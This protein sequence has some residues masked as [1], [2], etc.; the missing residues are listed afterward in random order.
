[1]HFSGI[2]RFLPVFV[3]DFVP[4]CARELPRT[5][6]PY[7]AGQRIFKG[8]E[9]VNYS[10]MLRFFKYSGLNLLNRN[11]G[12]LQIIRVGTVSI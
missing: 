3:R 10:E 7:F 6:P 2:S 1:M 12:R 8:I 5:I 9:R 4:V 11:D